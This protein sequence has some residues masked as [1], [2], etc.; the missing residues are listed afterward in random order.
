VRDGA[1]D[2][3][4]VVR[5]GAGSRRLHPVASFGVFNP[6]YE[7]AV[8]HVPG[9]E[10]LFVIG[11]SSE[12]LVV[13]AISFQKL[14]RIPILARSICYSSA[15]D[16]LYV[17]ELTSTTL[18]VLDGSSY[19]AIKQVPLGDNADWLFYNPVVDRVYCGTSDCPRFAGHF[20][21]RQVLVLRTQP[22]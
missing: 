9:A 17:A 14:K 7:L 4:G 2:L 13:D 20:L 12:V 16:K 18:H 1:G 5:V 3:A 19:Q 15:Q 8:D 11:E 6:P 22:G 21:R 10:R